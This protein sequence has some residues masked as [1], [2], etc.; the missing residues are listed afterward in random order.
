MHYWG[1]PYADFAGLRTRLATRA[2]PHPAN[3]REVHRLKSIIQS[4]NSALDDLRQWNDGDGDNP[5]TASLVRQI[6][7][8]RAEAVA[9]L[10]AIGETAKD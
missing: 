2:V 10:A 5:G 7:R 4:T 1:P 8:S 3:A 6:E 9:R